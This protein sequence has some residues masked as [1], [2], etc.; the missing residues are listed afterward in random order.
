MEQLVGS[1]EKIVEDLVMELWEA[2]PQQVM[3]EH[4]NKKKPEETGE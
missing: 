1:E 3:E 2:K 4:D